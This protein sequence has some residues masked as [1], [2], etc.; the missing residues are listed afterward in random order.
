MFSQ[1]TERVFADTDTQREG[2]LTVLAE[3]GVMRLQSRECEG[4]LGAPRN[5]DEGGEFFPGGF[6]EN[7]GL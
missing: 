4:L 7:T 6:A 5:W 3:T 2:H 1:D